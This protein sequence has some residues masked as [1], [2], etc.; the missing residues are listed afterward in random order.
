[1]NDDRTGRLLGIDLPVLGEPATDSIRLEKLEERL[2][3]RH[4]RTRRISE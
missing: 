4:L 2:L 1:M 3:I